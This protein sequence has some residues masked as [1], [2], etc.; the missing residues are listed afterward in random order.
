MI[1]SVVGNFLVIFNITCCLLSFESFKVQQSKCYFDNGF[2]NPTNYEAGDACM[3][4]WVKTQTWWTIW[5]DANGFM[6]LCFSEVLAIV[7]Y[8]LRA[9]RIQ[10]MFKAREIYCETDAMPKRLIWNWREAR[11]IR[12]FMSCVAF[13]TAVY[14]ALGFLSS[15]KVIDI[16]I[17]NYYVLSSPMKMD[18]K[19]C[20]VQLGKDIGYANASIS[21]M[22]FFEYVLLCCA[23]NA[24]WQIESE[25]NLFLELLLVTIVWGSCNTL[26][27]YIW[28]IDRSLQDPDTYLSMNQLRWVD[29]IMLSIRS[30]FC[31]LL[32]S[33]KPIY[34]SYMSEHFQIVPPV[35]NMSLDQF[36]NIL[37]NPVGIDYF[38]SYLEEQTHDQ[39]SFRLLALYMDLRLYES[40]AKKLTKHSNQ[41]S[42]DVRVVEE[43]P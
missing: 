24:Q 4:A 33:I 5:T 26:I 19:M 3:K 37:H 36:E 38:F 14:M 31:I 30:L 12:I 40:V 7:P 16:A 9:L 29:F 27:N 39:N 22:T 8:L 28:I 20:K 1:I 35:D 34:D 13:G 10:K 11:V 18:G 23:L 32:T 2:Y 6:L 41:S 15:F 25:Y 43:D 21:L 17:P 42:V